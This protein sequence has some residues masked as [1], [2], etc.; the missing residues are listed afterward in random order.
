MESI[1]VEI[2]EAIASSLPNNQIIEEWI[3][4]GA[5]TDLTERIIAIIV[6]QLEMDW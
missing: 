6:K 2:F 5:I 3:E 1:K 4:T